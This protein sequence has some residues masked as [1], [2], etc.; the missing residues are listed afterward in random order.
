MIYQ[1]HVSFEDLKQAQKLNFVQIVLF[2]ILCFYGLFSSG[3]PFNWKY[4]LLQAFCQFLMA[5]AIRKP[6]YSFVTFTPLLIGS[7][8]IQVVFYPVS[9]FAGLLTL[10]ICSILII[11]LYLVLNPLILP[12]VSWWEY[13]FRF[14]ADLKSIISNDGKETESRLVDFRRGKGSF[15]S[16]DEVPLGSK[17]NLKIETPENESGSELEG[18]ILTKRHESLGR[19]HHYGI[20]FSYNPEQKD[21]LKHL[22]TI[23]NFERK[24]KKLEKRKSV[25]SN[26]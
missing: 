10:A 21:K 17:V 14:R 9:L 3:T 25:Q 16:F 7:L 8:L 18:V 2:L 15:H 12:L 22:Q 26:I 4:F 11:E 6:S 23:W 13:D 20:S 19:G 24:A 1:N 5:R